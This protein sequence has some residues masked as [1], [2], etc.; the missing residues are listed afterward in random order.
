LEVSEQRFGSGE[1][2]VALLAAEVTVISH[3]YLSM[4]ANGLAGTAGSRLRADKF[5]KTEVI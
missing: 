1:G 2:V 5:Q 3:S 4:R